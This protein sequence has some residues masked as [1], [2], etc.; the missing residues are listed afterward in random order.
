MPKPIVQIQLQEE[1]PSPPT[2]NLGP[3]LKAHPHSAPSLHLRRSLLLIVNSCKTTSGQAQN[4]GLDPFFFPLKLDL[5]TFHPPKKARTRTATA[6]CKGLTSSHPRNRDNS[7]QR[8]TF[9][10]VNVVLV[11]YHVCSRSHA[12]WKYKQPSSPGGRLASFL[13]SLFN[14][15]A[16]KK[17]KSKSSAT[18]SMK[19]EEESPGGRRRR[20]SISHFRSSSTRDAKSVYSSSSS[21][22]RTPPPYSHAQ[23]AASKSYKDLRSYSDNH[24]QQY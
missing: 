15:S 17:K 8:A 2:T 6:C 22:F 12:A 1:D 20:S 13:N 11:V 21:G 23:T 5:E 9:P 7:V 16:S 19:D 24:K 4:Q 10:A 14:Q 3:I 18:Q